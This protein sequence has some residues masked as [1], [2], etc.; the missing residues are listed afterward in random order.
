MA[1]Y[2]GPQDAER[3]ALSASAL[4]KRSLYRDLVTVRSERAAGERL[5]T[6]LW[7]DVMAGVIPFVDTLGADGRPLR[8]TIKQE[9][10]AGL[11]HD[12]SPC[13]LRLDQHGRAIG[14]T[15]GGKSGLLDNIIA[16]LLRGAA[17]V[18]ICGKQKLYDLVMGWI[19]AYAKQSEYPIPIDWVVHGQQDT[20]EMLAGAMRL[21]RYRQNLL[22]DQRAGRVPIVVILDESSYILTDHDTHVMF[23]G[24]PRNASGLAADF[25]SGITSAG[26]Y[27]IFSTQ[28]DAQDRSGDCG[29]V[30]NANLGWQMC[31]KINDEGALGRLIDYKVPMPQ[32]RGQG[33]LNRRDGSFPHNIKVPYIQSIDTN[34]DVLHDGLTVADVSWARRTKTP[35]TLT[36]E[37][38]AV[39]GP[40][41]QQRHRFMS[42]KF[43]DYLRGNGGVG[44]TAQSAPI[45]VTGPKP[46]TVEDAALAEI[47]KKLVGEGVDL[48][49]LDTLAADVEPPAPPEP[50]PDLERFRVRPDRIEVIIARAGRAMRRADVIAELGTQFG[51]HIE[52]EQLVTNDLRRLV[53]GSRITRT[54]EGYVPGPMCRVAADQ[55]AP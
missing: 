14:G 10:V 45:V 39:V 20:C 42:D 3:I 29:D 4:F 40:L 53:K 35:M 1:D 28:Y 50:V 11:Y 26:C 38:A 22:P 49:A 9:M 13:G 19:E 48:S 41:Y 27:F 44:P 17:A 8:T 30:I 7:E 36:D 25:V 18:W 15:L 51:D 52:N 43:R 34:K 47:L 16:F 6:I 33:W 2:F 24:R 23:D 12:G 31:F 32:H 37:E 5:V 46:Q 55:C 21:G 54:L